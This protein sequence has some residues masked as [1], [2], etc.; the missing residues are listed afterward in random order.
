V[1]IHELKSWPVYFQPL[2]SGAK[3]FELRY[4]DRGFHVDDILQIREWDCATHKYTGRVVWMRVTSILAGGQLGLQPGNV[5]MSVAR[6]SAPLIPTM[7]IQDW[8]FLI[9]SLPAWL[10]LALC[11]FAL[12][13]NPAPRFRRALESLHDDGGE[14]AP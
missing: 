11:M 12:C 4:D 1:K 8:V 10:W 3:R 14:D 2:Y 6:L 9:L 5:I 13:R 7:R